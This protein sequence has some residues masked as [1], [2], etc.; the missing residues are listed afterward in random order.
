MFFFFL[1]KKIKSEITIPFKG[2]NL[3]LH[4]NDEELITTLFYNSYFINLTIG[5]SNQ[6]I[7]IK[8]KSTTQ[9][10][11]II[12]SNTT[13]YSGIKYNSEKSTTLKVLSK[14][15]IYIDEEILYGTLVKDNF[16]FGKTK[17][18]ELNFTLTSDIRK[19]SNI[20]GAGS[21]GLGKNIYSI[22]NSKESILIQLKKMNKIDHYTF[23]L[24]FT[25]KNEGNL[26]L[27]NY[28]YDIKKPIYL[29]EALQEINC[30]SQSEYYFSIS[31]SFYS[32]E[33]L[34][35]SSLLIF[36]SEIGL[37][38]GSTDYEDEIGK[39]FFNEYIKNGK[40]EIKKFKTKGFFLLNYNE[41]EFNYF[42]CDKDIKINKFP[43][44]IIKNSELSFDIVLN[45]EDLWLDYN[46][47]KYLMV[48]FPVSYDTD[49]LMRMLIGNIIF[50]KYDISFDSD[51]KIVLFYDKNKKSGNGKLLYV[52]L[53]T[54]ILIV[55][56]F[57]LISYIKKNKS[58]IIKKKTAKELEDD[59]FFT[60]IK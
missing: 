21:F 5:S 49:D 33:K 12:N 43:P 36:A 24:H 30:D 27:G 32:G 50:K 18:E 52:L 7:P 38:I 56:L 47:K 60:M 16:N 8:I 45:Y 4:L 3:P 1:L 51:R 9:L 58:R 28:L 31:S 17:I 23:T 29:M 46:N 39:Q 59:G 11:Y 34:L 15:N 42:V 14:K 44:L 54:V 40:C 25:N 20:K 22:E 13:S 37:I 6:E 48:V 10:S 41:K 55:A 53:I 26:I 2:Q 35:T 19:D 57:Y